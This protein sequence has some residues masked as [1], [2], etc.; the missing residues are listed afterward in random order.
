MGRERWGTFSVR[1]HTYKQPFA[2]DVLMYDQLVIP[3][4]GDA[5][6]RARWTKAK[7]AP[8]RL[9]SL[10]EVLRADS[11]NGRAITVPW[12]KQT[13]ELFRRRAD[14]ATIVDHEA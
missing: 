5:A 10:L 11:T 3:R 8:K 7:W 12:T 9:D 4:P 13:R 1:D 6:E 2:A 14:T